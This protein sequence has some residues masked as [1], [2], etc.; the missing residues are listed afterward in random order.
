VRIGLKSAL[1]VILTVFIVAIVYSPLVDLPL[2]ALQ[3]GTYAAYLAQA[4]GVAMLPPPNLDA[5]AIASGVIHEAAPA[6]L[7]GRDVV[8]ITCAFLC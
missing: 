1:A 7:Q 2:T 6:A 5:A 4:N 3:R 8:A